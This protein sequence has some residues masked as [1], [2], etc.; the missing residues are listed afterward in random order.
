MIII[1]KKNPCIIIVNVLIT[2]GIKLHS[3]LWRFRFPYKHFTNCAMRS[4]GD[5]Q[6]QILF[7]YC[8]GVKDTKR[9]HQKKFSLNLSLNTQSNEN[10]QSTSI[11]LAQRLHKALASSQFNCHAIQI[12][13]T[14]DYKICHIIQRSSVTHC[15]ESHKRFV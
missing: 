9:K 10:S 15:S 14:K 12:Y 5:G 11:D 8:I 1:K 13:C 3:K 4:D 6:M 2:A 7:V